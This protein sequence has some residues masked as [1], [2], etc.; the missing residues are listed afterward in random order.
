MSN[1]INFIRDEIPSDLMTFDEVEKKYRIKYHT[2]Y[3]YTCRENEIPYIKRG[4]S[5]VSERDV[6]A[7]LSGGKV[8]ARC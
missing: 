6:I 1:I 8:S 5:R 2:L 3:K 4:G 7:W